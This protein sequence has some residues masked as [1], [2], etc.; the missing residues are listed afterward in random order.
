[1]LRL[2]VCLI[3]LIFIFVAIPFLNILVDQ[4]NFSNNKAIFWR[5][6]LNCN[7]SKSK[8]CMVYLNLKKT[9][10]DLKEF[11]PNRLKKYET[12]L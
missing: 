2:A 8:H 11:S 7:I 4:L 1:M 5:Y 9:I 10:I 6:S 12:R 3:I